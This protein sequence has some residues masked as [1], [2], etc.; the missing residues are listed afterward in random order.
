MSHSPEPVASAIGSITACVRRQ[1]KRFR[2]VWQRRV[3]Q[4]RVKFAVAC[5][6]KYRN[7]V[8][9]APLFRP[10]FV[11]TYLILDNSIYPNRFLAPKGSR[12][13]AELWDSL[14]G[15]FQRLG[16]ILFRRDQVSNR[17]I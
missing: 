17:Q 12:A 1:N 14:D 6:G 8:A 9:K 2:F 13:G 7:D 4:I 15:Q 5:L 11:W 16:D 3:E 10:T